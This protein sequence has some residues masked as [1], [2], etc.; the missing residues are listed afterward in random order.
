MRPG[1]RLVQGFLALAVLGTVGVL[2]AG[3]PALLAGG[4]IGLAALAA[5][6]AWQL[7]RVP[8]EVERPETMALSLGESEQVPISVGHGASASIR[9]VLRSPWPRVLGGGAGWL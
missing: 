6:E 5:A 3:T 8:L 9:F 7:R 4:V 2:W 1:P